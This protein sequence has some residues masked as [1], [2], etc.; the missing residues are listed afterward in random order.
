MEYIKQTTTTF[1]IL[2]LILLNIR[3]GISAVMHFSNNQTTKH[4]KQER[5][6]ERERVEK[7]LSERPK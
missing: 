2:F 1:L 5:E 4:I 7:M 3:L 6:A